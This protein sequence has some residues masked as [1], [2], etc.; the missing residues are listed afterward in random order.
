MSCAP[1]S[2]FYGAAAKQCP[3]SLVQ[4]RVGKS[5]QQRNL[6]GGGMPA[7]LPAMRAEAGL[8]LSRAAGARGE[9]RQRQ[10]AGGGGL[11]S[12]EELG[13]LPRLAPLRLGGGRRGRVAA[14]RLAAGLAARGRAVPGAGERGVSRD[15]TACMT[16]SVLAS[17]FKISRGRVAA[18]TKLFVIR[19]RSRP[20]G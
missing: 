3:R 1:R 11:L 15:N 17:R 5:K 12:A 18:A 9:L 7:R 8:L 14:Q 20:R 13:R 6:W 16:C 10:A 4:P 2:V 19:R